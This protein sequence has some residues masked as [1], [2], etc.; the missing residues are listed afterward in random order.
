MEQPGP[1]DICSFL[2]Q[3]GW[4]YEYDRL[5]TIHTGW[6]EEGCHYGLSVIFQ[7]AFI[8]FEVRDLERY[9]KGVKFDKNEDFRVLISVC[10]DMIGPRLEYTA[11]GLSLLYDIPRVG[12]CYE[13][14]E[15]I[16]G[17]LGHYTETLPEMIA[18]HQQVV[19]EIFEQPQTLLI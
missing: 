6:E 4:D 13:Q 14:F 19:D 16:L 11:H 9:L 1:E 3:Y 10:S 12:F 18:Q 17:C 5:R 15:I 8:A 7:H 2:D